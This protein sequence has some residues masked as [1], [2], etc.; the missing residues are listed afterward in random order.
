MLT[1]RGSC[2]GVNR[3]RY[4][5]SHTENSPFALVRN[6]ALQSIDFLRL[7]LRILT[8]E[9]LMS[10]S[11]LVK[12][13]L[14]LLRH[15]GAAGSGRGFLALRAFSS[16]MTRGKRAGSCILRLL[17]ST[18][19]VGP[20]YPTQDVEL[21]VVLINASTKRKLTLQKTGNL[22]NTRSNWCLG[23]LLDTTKLN[24]GQQIPRS[25]TEFSCIQYI[26]LTNLGNIRV[27]S[28]VPGFRLRN[29]PRICIAYA[30]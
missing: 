28:D 30:L 6:N 3:S 21:L 14:G 9:R 1:R 5:A 12:G 29:T 23:Y 19:W 20:K 26:L 8:D 13:L 27:H 2:V 11:C 17:L 16:T 15:P 22:E 4:Y 10:S 25:V 7:Y 24:G 18:Q